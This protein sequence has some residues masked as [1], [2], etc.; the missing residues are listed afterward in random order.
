MKKGLYGSA[1]IAV[2][3]C[4]LFFPACDKKKSAEFS[5]DVKETIV[6]AGW[7]SGDTAFKA[8]MTGFNKQYPDIDVKL[9]FT[10]TTSHHQALST[11]LVA[12]S[13]APD[14][15]MVEGAYIAQ[16]RDSTALVNLLGAP[17]NAGELK[18]DFVAF[19]WNQCYSS[20]GKNLDA[21]PWDI[22]PCAYYYRTD[23]FRECGLPTDPKE[24]AELMKTW[25]G[26]LKVAKAVCVSGKRWFIPDASYLYFELFIN[27]DY[28]DKKL[29]LQLNRPGDID[30]LNAAITVRKNKWDM[31]ADMWSAEAYAA[32]ADGSCA[33]VFTGCW[34]GG[35]LKDDIDPNG[36]GHWAVTTLPAGVAGSN[37]GGSFLVIPKQCKH[38]DAAWKFIKYMLA[39]K[40][41]QNDMYNAVDY[42]PAY[43]PAWED[44]SIYEKADPYFGGEK[45][46]E[47]Y[48]QIANELKPIV[49]TMMDTTAEGCIFSSVNAGLAD[50]LDASAIRE[51]VRS[52]I[53]TATAEIK[54]QQ[55]QI[56]QDA[57]VWEK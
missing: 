5:G 48:I 44:K 22:G 19:K 55:I 25:D 33:S 3:L 24:V 11:S 8:A 31:N 13:G 2:C 15:A 9:Q 16:Y 6:V 7:P 26:V 12:G 41:G 35:F 21:I 23:I 30:A 1:G 17:Y 20:D 42:F 43:K 54:K 34:F 45:T 51:R 40:Q 56:F 4:V 18:N 53:E 37:W 27:R 10:D 39:T 46:G 28:Y 47:V 32:Y 49:T 52:D 36:A 29:D 14:V 50:N 57:G 38:K